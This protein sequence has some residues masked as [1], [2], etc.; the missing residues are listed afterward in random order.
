MN[1]RLFVGGAVSMF[2]AGVGATRIPPLFDVP[3]S[4]E[5]VAWHLERPIMTYEVWDG[6][7]YAVTEFGGKVRF[8]RL[9]LDPISHA[10]PPVP[11]WQLSGS[12]ASA[13]LTDD[14]AEGDMRTIDTMHPTPTSTPPAQVTRLS[15]YEGVPGGHCLGRNSNWLDSPRYTRDTG[16]GP[17]HP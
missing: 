11:R 14:P 16:R 1:R 9:I 4:I 5:D 17:G 7:P 10:W 15:R 8:D 3:K 2:A 12:W 6:K 13:E